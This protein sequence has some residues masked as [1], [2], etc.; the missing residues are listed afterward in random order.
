MTLEP[1]WVE[2]LEKLVARGRYPS[3][4]AAVDKA[5]TNFMF[6][7]LEFRDLKAAIDEGL[8]SGLAE[9]FSFADVAREARAEFETRQAQHRPAAE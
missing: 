7:E 5:L 1:H 6:E 4:E 3:V 2:Y 9:P 8:E